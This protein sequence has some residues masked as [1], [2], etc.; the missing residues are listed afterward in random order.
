MTAEEILAKIT[1]KIN[2][3]LVI[4]N[5]QSIH[6]SVDAIFEIMQE[7]TKQ[8]AEAFAEWLLQ[9]TIISGTTGKYYILLGNYKNAGWQHTTYELYLQFKNG[10]K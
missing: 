6:H 4:D 2:K 5:K 1:E 10:E 9:N 7:Y 8:E 3:H